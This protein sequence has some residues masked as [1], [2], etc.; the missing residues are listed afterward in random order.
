M[1]CAENSAHNTKK[2]QK[3]TTSGFWRRVCWNK[4]IISHRVIP[5]KLDQEKKW[6]QTRK[7]SFKGRESHNMTW[8]RD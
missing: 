1:S 2:L 6:I 8:N 7:K 5:S 3:V 4:T